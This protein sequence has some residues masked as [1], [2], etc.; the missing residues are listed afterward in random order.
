MLDADGGCDSAVQPQ[1]DLLGKIREYL[2]IL[3]EKMVL[4]KTERCGILHLCE[5]LPDI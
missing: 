1:S 4:V 3:T 2:P 5:E